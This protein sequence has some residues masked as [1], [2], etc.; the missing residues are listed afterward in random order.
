VTSASLGNNSIL[1]SFFEGASQPQDFSL[2]TSFEDALIIAQTMNDELKNEYN[3]KDYFSVSYSFKYSL[4]LSVVPSDRILTLTTDFSNLYFAFWRH[5]NLQSEPYVLFSFNYSNIATRL[6]TFESL[7]PLFLFFSLPVLLVAALLG[8]FSLGLIN[9]QR[10]KSFAVIK[11][12]GFSDRFVFLMMFTETVILAITTFFL[13]L[14][15]GLPLSLL[16]GASSGLLTFN[17]PIDPSTLVL[18]PGTMLSVFYLS[19][20]LTFLLHLPSL[21][22]L[23]RSVALSLTEVGAKRTRER[24]RVAIGKLDIICLTLGSAGVFLALVLTAFLRTGGQVTII[25]GVL[26]PILALIM[27]FSPLLFFLG[28]F[29][30]FSRFVPVIIKK[31][32]TCSWQKNWFS[33]AIA[34]RNLHVNAGMTG[35]ITVLIASSLALMVTFTIL[36]PSLQLQSVDN[37]Y[38]TIGGEICY[39]M[40]VSREETFL[41]LV[42]DLKNVTGFSFTT[43]KEF[44]LTLYEPDPYVQHGLVPETTLFMGIEE[45]FADFAHWQEYYDDQSLAG[46]VDALFASSHNNSAII[47]S[48]T[49]FTEQLTIGDSYTLKTNEDTDIPLSIQAASNYW[50]RMVAYSLSAFVITQTS[51]IENIAPFIGGK[52]GYRNTLLG[53]I[54]PGHHRPQV[55][56]EIRALVEKWDPDYDTR[57]S[58]SQLQIIDEVAILQADNISNIFVWFVANANVLAEVV[59]VLSAIILFTVTRTIRHTREIALARSL[60]MKSSQIFRLVF[61]ETF[62]LVVLGGI[63]GTVAGCCLL[64]GII[65]QF[66]LLPAP[67]GP[68]VPLVLSIDFFILIGLYVLVFFV[69]TVIGLVSSIMTTRANISKIL[70]VE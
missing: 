46:L 17:R 65:A 16:L 68:V 13:A 29:F 60:G 52:G 59:I 20:V 58:S 30:F 31:I 49:L 67:P 66:A 2:L 33:L 19:G 42:T 10:K 34:T 37:A 48:T 3:G 24:F 50:P 22:R 55:I 40:S 39:S 18:T 69:A 15:I 32:G 27:L 8:S 53:K 43:I 63:L 6:A 26:L 14:F 7:F 12:R 51:F 21:Y 23:S 61:T 9:E 1:N 11:A 45:D 25:F 28:F 64:I 57:Y 36:A 54:L 4:N 70:K 44:E 38:Y 56:S 41:K 47:D 5:S 35:R 62:L